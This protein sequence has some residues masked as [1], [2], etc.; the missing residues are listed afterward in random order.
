MSA[1]NGVLVG[2]GAAAVVVLAGMVAFK[3]MKKKNPDMIEKASKS[4]GNVRGKASEAVK[5]AKAAF[6]E[7][8][9]SIKESSAAAIAAG[10]ETEA[11]PAKA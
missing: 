10:G 1:E 3:V 2:I 7:G 5:G 6:R 9:A 11:A 4:V 8:F